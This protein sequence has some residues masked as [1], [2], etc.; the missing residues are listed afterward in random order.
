MAKKKK[1]AK[2]KVKSKVKTKAKA[3]TK[4]KAKAKKPARAK[5]K[6]PAK[7]KKSASKAKARKK[8]AAK[9]KMSV[10]PPPNST[11]LGRVEDFYAHINVIAFTLKAPIR[12]GDRMQ[13]LGHTTNVEQ[14]V[15]SMQIN[16][17]GVGEAKATDAIGIKISGRARRGDYVFRLNG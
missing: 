13:V 5:A 15:D 6:K 16:H 12:V 1:V 8:A 14:N 3:K 7:A 4:T 2:K 10:I 11:L 9:P 17:Q